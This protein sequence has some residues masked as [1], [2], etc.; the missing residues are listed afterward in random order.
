[1]RVC[2]IE[3]CEREPR[4]GRRICNACEHATARYG[5]PHARAPRVGKGQRLLAEL[6]LIETDE[7]ITWPLHTVKGYGYVRRD[8][9]DVGVHVIACEHRHG[10]P[11][12]PRHEVAHSCI[13]MRACLN[14]RHLRWATRAEN[15]ADMIEHDTIARGERRPGH[16]LT[17]DAVREIRE[18][19]ARG[20]ITQAALAAEF[21]V[22]AITIHDCITRRTWAW[23]DEA[24]A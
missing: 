12:S 23:L 2:R 9:R 4:P 11:P 16:K 24:A 8:G 20:G 6:L 14:Y 7:C 13:E 10:P 15:V 17:E 22:S 5:D 19:Y 18:R 1:M 3:G 21:D